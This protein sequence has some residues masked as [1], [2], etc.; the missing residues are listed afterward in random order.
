MSN[1]SM[2]FEEFKRNILQSINTCSL[3]RIV[4]INGNKASVQPLF[5]MKTSDGKLLKQTLIN[6]VPITKHCIDDAIIGATVVYIAA[7]RSIANLNGSNFID[8]AAHT[9]M[10]D[11]DAIILG[12]L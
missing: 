10:S 9:L 1:A 12:V 5:M 8:P 3:G 2:F 4:S 7:Q 6:D 11:N